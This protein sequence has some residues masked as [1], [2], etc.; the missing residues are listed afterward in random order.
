MFAFG[1][2]KI[3]KL[4]ISINE[5]ASAVGAESKFVFSFCFLFVGL[6]PTPIKAPNKDFILD[7]SV[8]KKQDI[9]CRSKTDTNTKTY[10]RSKTDTNKRPTLIKDRH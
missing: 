9:Y 1:E 6:R 3:K 4:L 10:C 5:S 8:H 7:Q 2:Q